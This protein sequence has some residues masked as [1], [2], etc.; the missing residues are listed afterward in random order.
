MDALTT[1]WKCGRVDFIVA[2]EYNFLIPRGTQIPR[3]KV[4]FGSY[5]GRRRPL[6]SRVSPV[7]FWIQGAKQAGDAT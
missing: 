6:G 5:T 3:V 1:A 2:V 4:L 7:F